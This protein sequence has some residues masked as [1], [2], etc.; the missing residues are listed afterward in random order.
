VSALKDG[1]G[2][3]ADRTEH[4]VEA[5][6]RSHERGEMSR[7]TFVSLAAA[8]IARARTQG[9]ALADLALTAEVMRALGNTMRPVGLRAPPDDFER[10]R[11]SVG[12]VLD[13]D[14]ASVETELDRRESVAKRLT[15]LARDSSAEAVVW[16]TAMVGQAHGLTGWVRET[17]LQPCIVCS[18]LADGVSR[19]YSVMMKRHTGCLCVQRS[20]I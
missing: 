20:V 11:G 10:L 16:A 8:L 18:N 6:F 19:P 1:V 13:Q 3:L 2:R 9:V 17:S 14:V 15:R 4:R 12:T 5:L 7:D